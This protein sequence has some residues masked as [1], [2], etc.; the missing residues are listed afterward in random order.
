MRSLS[1]SLPITEYKKILLSHGSGGKLT[2]ELINK[3]FLPSFKNEYLEQLMD[4][5]ILN[6][7]NKRILFT[8]DSYVVNPIFFS[9]GDIGKLA[10]YGT[11]NDLAVCGAIPLYLSASFILEEGF[12]IDKLYRIVKSMEVA[13]KKAN[14]KIVTGD[15]KVVEKGKGDGI[16]INTSGIGVLHE[17]ANLAYN[18]IK[19]G[20]KILINGSIGEHGIAILESRGELEFGTSFKSDC[21]PLTTLINNLLNCCEIHFMR[22]P[23]RGGIASA[24]NEITKKSKFKI[25]IFEEKVPI[26][27][28]VEDACSILGINPFHI[29]NEGKVLVFVKK[30]HAEE[31]LKIMRKHRYGKKAAIIGEVKREKSGNVVLE[32]SIG[33]EIILDSLT[34]EQL[35]RI[36]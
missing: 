19:P 2:Q 14:I 17:K 22:D 15:T 28:S 36:C 6:I 5:A 12:E 9:G 20:D 10:I 23:T 8:T 25:K 7:K 13:S 33:A 31:A 11:V 21:A 3:F 34:G 4:S 27:K 18:K 16:Y 35:P 1:C 26:S 29:A 32:T 30:E 24:L